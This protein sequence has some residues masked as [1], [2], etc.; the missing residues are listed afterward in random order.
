MKPI[1]FSI[2]FPGESTALANRWAADLRHTLEETHREVRVDQAPGREDTMDLGA[3]LSIVLGSAAVTVVAKGIQA[4]LSK[5]Q[6]ASIEMTKH[7]KVIAK[8]LRGKDALALAE[9][10]LKHKDS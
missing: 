7:G 2:S 4:W 5:H 10:I 1:Q 6:G 3:T 9:I 8:G